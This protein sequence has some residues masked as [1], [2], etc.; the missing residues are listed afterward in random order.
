MNLEILNDNIHKEIEH[1]I[2]IMQL[3]RELDEFYLNV[4]KDINIEYSEEKQ[5]I[6]VTAKN[7]TDWTEKEHEQLC[8]QFQ[9]KL[10]SFTK[11]EVTTVLHDYRFFAIYEYSN[12]HLVGTSQVL[13]FPSKAMKGVMD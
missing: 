7:L 3:Q 13:E 12:L 6:V 11:K 5:K 4:G 8:E 9:C 2:D 1:G 10:F